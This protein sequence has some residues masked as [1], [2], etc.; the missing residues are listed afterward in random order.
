MKF[1]KENKALVI[2]V[3]LII[4]FIASLMLTPKSVN[5]I[6]DDATVSEWLAAAKGEDYTILTLAQTTCSH[7]Q[8]FLPVAKKFAEK[9]DIDFYWFDV[10][11]LGQDDYETLTEQF[12]NFQGT[13]YTVVLKD[14][15]IKGE[16][17]G[18]VDLSTLVEDVE[19][20][21]VT[22]TERTAE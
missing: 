17:S 8:N 4:L 5:Y 18:E 15:K 6:I 19:T 11:Q 21:G 16:I 9:Y 7:C 2:I 1:I 3:A 14:G 12:E 10:D 20:A 22:L 13:P